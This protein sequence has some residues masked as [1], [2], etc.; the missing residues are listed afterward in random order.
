MRR[1]ALAIL[2]LGLAQVGR[3][4]F[5]PCLHLSDIRESDQAINCLVAFLKFL[6]L[7][8]FYQNYF[9]RW[10]SLTNGAT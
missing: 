2:A 6:D 4:S 8:Q 9:I 10:L 5:S 3:P 1:S 7:F